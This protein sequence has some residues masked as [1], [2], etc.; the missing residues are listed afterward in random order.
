MTNVLVAHAVRLRTA[1]LLL[2]MLALIA[3]ILA[4][5]ILAGGHGTGDHGSP[6]GHSAA[7]LPTAGDASALPQGAASNHQAHHGVEPAGSNALMAANLTGHEIGP[8]AAQ[9]ALPSHTEC[10][11]SC[12]EM[13]VLSCV[14]AL[15]LLGLAVLPRRTFCLRLPVPRISMGS[16]L[17]LHKSITPSSLSPVQLSIS[18]T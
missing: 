14:L 18:R 12:P 10:H 7:A 8:A 11:E 4:L 1:S 13:I 16:L 15:T 9:G 17:F 3:G 6:S 5:H 2:T